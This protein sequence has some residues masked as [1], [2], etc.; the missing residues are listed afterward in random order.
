MLDEAGLT[1]ALGWY[2]EGLEARSGLK[3][4]LDAPQKFERIGPE[5]ELLIFRVVQECLTNIYRHA[6]S[7]TATIRL[8]IEG[9]EIKLSVE[10]QGRGIDPEKLETVRHR[11]SGVG[12]QGMRERVRQVNGQ[13]DI[14][15]SSA[16]TVV[17]FSFPGESR[18]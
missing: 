14:R 12:L 6:G 4:T 8:A 18:R 11:G 15:S 7:K 13:M 17:S 10:D 9:R 1:A 2:V 3:I 16:G 5:M